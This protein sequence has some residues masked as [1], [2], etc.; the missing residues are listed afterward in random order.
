MGKKLPK[1]EVG[2]IIILKEEF[3]D[4]TRFKNNHQGVIVRVDGI[5]LYFDNGEY[6]TQ[7]SEYRKSYI[8]VIKSDLGKAI[9]GGIKWN[10]GFVWIKKIIMIWP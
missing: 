9:Y 6:F 4:N 2:D 1:V 10:T 5:R 7:D 8:F 3:H